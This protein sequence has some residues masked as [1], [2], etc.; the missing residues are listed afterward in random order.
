M[1]KRFPTRFL[2]AILL[3]LWLS[4]CAARKNELQARMLAQQNQM[5]VHDEGDNLS[6]DKAADRLKN[7]SPA[8]HLRRGNEA[9]ELQDSALATLHYTLALAKDASLEAAY[10][11]LAEAL[12]LE[13]KSQNAK[14][15]LQKSLT[16]SG[17]R[18]HTLAR[19]G[20]L[21]RSQ[22]E[23]KQSL[24][25]LL[26]AN[27][28]EPGSAWLMTELAISYEQA[29]LVEK[30]ETYF[31]EAARQ[32]PE[33][34]VALNN[35]GFNYLLQARYARAVTILQNALQL[36]PDN[37]LTKNNLALAR[38][39]NDNPRAALHLF[40]TTVGKAGAY[41]NLGYLLMLQQHDRDAE[42]ALSRAL[43]LDPVFYVRAQQNLE[44][45]KSGDQIQPR[46]TK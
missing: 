11:G 8:E 37:Q 20:T 45:L 3:L 4:G 32:L 39:L 13:G 44:L 41:N 35:L 18:L 10:L 14:A 7:L 9:L 6:A 42:Q 29:G 27:Q 28:L 12:I 25:Y 24:Q 17:Q 46:L 23:N 15:V 19:L 2:A 38:A 31:R 43:E 33:S 34:A 22:G 1:P 40:E 5:L 16:Q 26:Q 21:C 30:A 36:A